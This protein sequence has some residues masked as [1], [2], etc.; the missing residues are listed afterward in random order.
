[1][2]LCS[3]RKDLSGYENREKVDFTFDNLSAL[4]EDIQRGILEGWCFMWGQIA[5]F[6]GDEDLPTIPGT[7]LVFAPDDV[8]D[9]TVYVTTQTISLSDGLGRLKE[10]ETNQ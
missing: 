1:M 7:V 8:A 10:M 6:L 3:M 5:A 2:L 4:P 9:K